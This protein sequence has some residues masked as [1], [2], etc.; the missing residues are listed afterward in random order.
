MKGTKADIKSMNLEELKIEMEAAGEK[1]FRAKQMY[2]WMHG[3]LFAHCFETGESA[4]VF[5]GRNKEIFI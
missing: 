2:E 5:V 4:G 1:S 3:K